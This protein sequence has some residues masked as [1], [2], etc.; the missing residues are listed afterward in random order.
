[1]F[2]LGSPCQYRLRQRVGSFPA[3]SIHF[4]QVNRLAT[5]CSQE[6]R[7][8]PAPNYCGSYIRQQSE[9]AEENLPS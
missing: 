9:S 6:G 2:I 3:V 8:T 1:M 5:K 4:A 7:F